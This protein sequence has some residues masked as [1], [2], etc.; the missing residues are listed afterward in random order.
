MSVLDDVDAWSFDEALEDERDLAAVID[1]RH[2]DEW[3][4]LQEAERDAHAAQHST[5]Q[6]APDEIPP[7]QSGQDYP[8]SVRIEC[9]PHR[10][11]ELVEDELS[12]RVAEVLDGCASNPSLVSH[13]KSSVALPVQKG[14][15]RKRLR[16]KQCAPADFSA[17]TRPF[18]LLRN[19]ENIACFLSLDP[20][21]Q[22]RLKKNLRL[23]LHRALHKLRQGGQM[24]LD[25]G[26]A[27]QG[28]STLSGEGIET[29]WREDLMWDWFQSEKQHSEFRGCVGQRLS[30]NHVRDLTVQK[31]SSSNDNFK[32]AT[33][34]LTWQGDFGAS[35]VSVQEVRGMTVD[36]LTSYLGRHSEVQK[37][38]HGIRSQ[39]EGVAKEFGLPGV[40]VSLE[41]CT[42]TWSQQGIVRLHVHSW[43][44][45]GNNRKRLAL[46]DLK[47]PAA[48]TP[49]F[50][51]V[52]SQY[53]SRNVPILC[54]ILHF[55][56]E[57]W[58][59]S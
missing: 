58:A 13:E 1:E 26:E 33:V 17:I 45:Q 32:A 44:L 22:T 57:I 42:R 52:W 16:G 11:G 50:F 28:S 29:R 59:G 3:D 25:N 18:H 20:E 24:D 9:D 21:H 34:L 51:S 14:P 10:N 15:S 40:A 48:K 4:S 43:L 49:F 31:P 46:A 5:S 55:V 47:I 38:W 23:S 37:H 39:Y 7:S 6:P 36:D 56:R 35:E 2:M 53:S 27:L 54:C 19:N 12:Q 30:A 8:G 41:L